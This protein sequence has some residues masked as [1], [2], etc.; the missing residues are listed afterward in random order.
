MVIAITREISPR[1]AECELTHMERIPIDV[2]LARAQHC[3]YGNALRELGYTVIE[4]PAEADLPDS[5]RADSVHQ[6]CSG[7]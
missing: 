2:D 5:A 7:P 6:T 1:F 3:A 4:L